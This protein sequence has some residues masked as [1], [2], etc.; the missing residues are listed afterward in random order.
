[1]KFKYRIIDTTN[2]QRAGD[3]EGESSEQIADSFLSQGFTI[4]ELKPHGFNL[5]KLKSLN[6][7]GIPFKDKVV[8]MRQM[9]FMINAGLPL[10]QALEIAKEQITNNSFREKIDRVIKSV[11][12]GA[13]LSHSFDKEKGT[14]DFVT[15]NL[16]KA[17]EE[18]GKLDMIMNRVA[19]DMEKKQEFQGK[20]TGALIYPIV[21][22]IAI[23]GVVI[24]LLVFM[25]PQMSKLYA[26]SKAKLPFL[27][28][29]VLDASNFLT[30]GPGGL[31]LGAL[32]ISGVIGFIYYRKT[33]SGR[34]VTDKYLLRIPIFGELAKKS[35]VATFARTFAMLITAGVPILDALKLVG[36]STTNMLFKLEIFEARK[37][38]EKGLPLSAP[39]MNGE[40]FPILLGH[41]V[42]VGEET[43][44]I[45][46]VISKVGEQYAK[47]VDMMATNLSRLMEPIILISMGFVVG[48]LALA[49]YLPVLNLGSAIGG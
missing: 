8:F 15:T 39:L 1:M 2:R 21:I 22:I 43:G 26:G 6:V 4:L 44:K 41:M 29:I 7:G 40:A 32:V 34:F 49:V 20:V 12:S 5:D 13:T 14:L 28:Q 37:K 25:I 30:Q 31:I 47:E 16:L 46:E 42:K 3:I 24:A 23:I 35:Q 45:D 36:D 19:D 17:G 48:G 9:S 10:T 27:T 11:S 38:V 18:S 33:P